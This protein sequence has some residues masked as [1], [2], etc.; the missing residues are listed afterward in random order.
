[1]RGFI[2]YGKTTRRP[3]F[4]GRSFLV[5]AGS[6]QWAELHRR[7]ISV[8]MLRS[9]VE[10]SLTYPSKSMSNLHHPSDYLYETFNGNTIS[11]KQRRDL[12]E[13]VDQQAQLD[14]DDHSISNMGNQSPSGLLWNLDSGSRWK[15]DGEVNIV[16]YLGK[17]VA[18]CCVE[19]SELHPRLGIGGIRCWIDHRHRSS[20]LPS[21]FML[22]SNLSWCLRNGKWGMMMSFN[23]HNKI[24]YDAI[25]RSASG[26]SPSVGNGWSDWWKDCIIIRD[27][28]IIRNTLQWCV[29]KP[30][31]YLGCQM[32]L[33]DIGETA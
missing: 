32:I 16:R 7:S 23:D 8:I 21:R 12:G 11:D 9:I 28:L 20:H 25:C 18:V 29:I 30:I 3:S 4:N 5:Y 10:I 22:P 17:V 1:M 13:F 33:Q 24:L 15:D 6:D 31:N 2:A 19:G 26:R 27:R 14:P